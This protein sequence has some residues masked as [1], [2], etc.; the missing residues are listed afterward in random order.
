MYLH[1]FELSKKNS[2]RQDNEHPA[3]TELFLVHGTAGRS[4]AAKNKETPPWSHDDWVVGHVGLLILTMTLKFPTVEYF[5]GDRSYNNPT[6]WL[7][8]SYFCV[9]QHDRRIKS[10][11][12]SVFKFRP[13][14]KSIDRPTKFRKGSITISKFRT[15]LFSPLASRR[16]KIL[17]QYST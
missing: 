5:L 8:C 3:Y 4:R 1:E 15:H 10:S 16:V 2:G 9:I 11:R 14:R 12:R 13:C 7:S 17:S 6:Y